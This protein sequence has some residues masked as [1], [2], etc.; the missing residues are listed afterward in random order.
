MSFYNSY[1]FV[2]KFFFWKTF[3]LVGLSRT[4][5]PHIT[6]QKIKFLLKTIHKPEFIPTY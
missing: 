6:S 2:T 3:L 4:T 5:I 1:Y